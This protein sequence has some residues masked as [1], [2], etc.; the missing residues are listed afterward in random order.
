MEELEPELDDLEL[1]LEP[2]LEE[3]EPELDDLELELEPERDDLEL[4]SWL[5]E[6][7]LDS[8]PVER[9]LVLSSERLSPLDSD[10][11]LTLES[12]FESSELTAF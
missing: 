1:E 11:S 4:E 7:E 3:L 6:S 10:D 8:D 2:D 9:L 5:E 12:D